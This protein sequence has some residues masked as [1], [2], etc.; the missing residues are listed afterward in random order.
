MYEI[1]EEIKQ[2]IDRGA[3]FVIN[4]S[5]GKDS[6]AMTIK[7]RKI[8]PAERIL[9]IH[10]DLPEADWP[11]TWDHVVNTCDGL[12]IQQVVAVKTFFDMVRHRQMWPSPKYR[13]CT[14]DL[15]RGPIE[16]SIRHHI[17]ENNLDGLVVNCMGIRAE[18]SL[19]L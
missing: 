6:Q 13:Q 10:A 5:G 1:N 3:L 7:L 16:K 15:K 9:V 2:L 11:G 17:K 8:V 14:S 19:L 18:E 12:E 4:H